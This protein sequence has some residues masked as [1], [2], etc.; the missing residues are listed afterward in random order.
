[1]YQRHIPIYDQIEKKKK[2]SCKITSQ[3]V[4]LRINKRKNDT[5]KT[6]NFFPIMK[7]Q[8]K[9]PKSLWLINMI[10][11]TC[12]THRKFKIGI[13]P[14]ISFLKSWLK[15]YID[16]NTHLRKKSKKWFCKRFFKLMNNTVFEKTMENLRKYRDIKLVATERRKNY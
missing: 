4:T 16:T 11:W 7:I 1:M 14:W 5:N 2:K 15:S 3:K 12:Y 9:K 13:K 10:N 8:L 6:T